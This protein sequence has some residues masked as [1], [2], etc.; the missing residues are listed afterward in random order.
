ME[1]NAIRAVDPAWLAQ[2]RAQRVAQ[3]LPEHIDDPA[4]IGRIAAVVRQHA[5]GRASTD[6]PQSRQRRRKVA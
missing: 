6:T 5:Q 3:G 1:A 4:S 2:M